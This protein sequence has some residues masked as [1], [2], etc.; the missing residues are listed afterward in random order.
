MVQGHRCAATIDRRKVS[1]MPWGTTTV[2]SNSVTASAHVPSAIARQPVTHAATVFG[3]SLTQDGLRLK[4]SMTTNPSRPLLVPSQTHQPPDGPNSNTPSSA[5]EIS[6]AV[7]AQNP[8]HLLSQGQGQLLP[9]APSRTFCDDTN[10]SLLRTD[11]EVPAP[12]RSNATNP[13]QPGNLDF[14]GGTRLCASHQ[15]T[16]ILDDH[17]RF[18]SWLFG[19]APTSP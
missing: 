11:D 8:R 16:D 5:S 10:A 1:I 13:V 3:I 18:L 7:A 6:T 2:S 12:Q 4:R 19:R 17:S 9:S 15:S 14:K